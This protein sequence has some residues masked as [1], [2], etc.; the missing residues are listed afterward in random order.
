MEVV[1]AIYHDQCIGPGISVNAFTQSSK[2]I[3]NRSFIDSSRFKEADNK[4]NLWWIY[5]MLMGVH[6]ILKRECDKKVALLDL[7]RADAS[8]YLCVS[9][10]MIHFNSQGVQI[11]FPFIV[12]LY[13][14]GRLKMIM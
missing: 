6:E 12:Q 1:K 7:S 9:Y 3:A 4:T 13:L 2:P 5:A 11:M 10:D 8:F 14:L